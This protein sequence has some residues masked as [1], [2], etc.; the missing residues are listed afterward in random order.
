MVYVNKFYV[1]GCKTYISKCD[2]KIFLLGLG[3]IFKEVLFRHLYDGLGERKVNRNLACHYDSNGAILCVRGASK[4]MLI[5]KDN[6]QYFVA[7]DLTPV[8]VIPLIHVLVYWF[9]MR[10]VTMDPGIIPK[11]SLLYQFEDE[12]EMPLKYAKFDPRLISDS[13]TIQIRSHAF[14]IKWC[15]TCKIFKKTI[16]YIYRPPRA[17]HCPCCDNC[18]VRFDH[19]CPWLG[20]CVGRRNYRYFYTFLTCLTTLMAF[21]LGYCIKYILLETDRLTSGNVKPLSLIW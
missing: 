1:G 8:I 7:F 11:I 21:Q 20:A 13:K 9:A 6:A 5:N 3:N 14:K 16:G 19:H 2:P 15:P 12:M 4:W 18:V 17:S 10:A